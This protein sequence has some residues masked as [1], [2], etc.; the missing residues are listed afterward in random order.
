[1]RTDGQEEEVHHL[2]IVT[3]KNIKE[4][5]LPWKESFEPLPDGAD[6][7]KGYGEVYKGFWDWYVIGG[8]YE[9]T[10]AMKDGYEDLFLNTAPKQAID[11]EQ[12]LEFGSYAILHK[13][14]L[15]TREI[16]DASGWFDRV[17]DRDEWAKEWRAV[18]DSLPDD[19]LLTIVDCH[20]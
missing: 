20:N 9:G 13:G 4:Q 18:I 11:F 10:F 15:H 8:R 12:C 7:P 14:V 2:L 16:S 5:M 3:G 17:K 6:D 19:T 1:M